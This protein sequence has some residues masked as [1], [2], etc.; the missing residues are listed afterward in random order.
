MRGR[1]H[2]GE[3]LVYETAAA[4]QGEDFARLMRLLGAI[5]TPA[6]VNETVDSTLMVLADAMGAGL[7]CVASVVGDRLVPTAAYGVTPDDPVFQSGWAL[8]GPGRDALDRGT[9]VARAQ[10][11]PMDRP[12]HLRRA[13]AA[14]GAWVPLTAGAD[15]A[16]ELL[17]LLRLDGH[18]F[19]PAELQVLA[20][21]AYQMRSAVEALERVNA[22][23]R[24]AEAGPGL[25]RHV[26]LPSLWDEAVVLLR[27][28]TGTDSAF[29]VTL[30]NDIF[31]LATYTGTDESIPRRWPRTTRTMPNWDVLSTGRAYVGPREVI[32][33]R[34]DET[35]TSPTVLC[36]PVMQEGNVVALLG[37]TGHRS[38]SFGKTGVDIATVLANYLSAAV[39]KAHLY[40]S[41]MQR[42]RELRRR[43]SSDPLTGLAN[44][45]QL[46][47][48]IAAALPT[49]GDSAVGLLFCDIDKFK[50]VNDR[51]GHEFGDELLQQV[52]LR[53]RTAIRPGDV[54]ARFGGDEFVVI[55]NDVRDLA[56]VTAASRV[57]HGCLGAPFAIR[58]EQFQVSASIGAV[59]G[60]S[61]TTASVLL[62]SADAAMYE[63]KAKGC[64]RTEVFD[65]DASH[66]SMDRL[67]LRAELAFALDRGELAIVYQ[68]ICEL[69]SRK[70][71]AFEALLRWTHPERGVVVPDLFIPLAEETGSIVPIGAWVLRESCRRLSEWQ[72]LV[73]DANLTMGVNITAVQL[74]NS[75]QDLLDV[76]L[77]TGVDPDHVW[78]EVTERM[79]TSGDIADQ[80]ARLRSAGVHFALDDFGMSYSSLMY[81]KRF[82]V[83]GIKIDRTFV[84]PMT[85]DETE[86]AIVQAILAL[87]A[88][89]SVNVIAEGIETDE[90]ADALLDLGCVY[91]QGYLLG[92]PM[93]AAESV[94]ALQAQQSD[95]AGTRP[96]EAR[97]TL[98]E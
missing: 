80:V 14:S 49:A 78:L 65:D 44:R 41:L 57:I 2:H 56:D 74:E 48:Q 17:V 79:D 10:V 19:Q 28:L 11:A 89:L 77:R 86:L 18:E 20:T 4:A 71:L 9:P 6:P 92:R 43:A 21:A 1:G 90:Q 66:R 24:L 31:T 27:D 36:V 84:A 16:D 87:G 96:A 33:E 40:R 46:S 59:L 23:E 81:L 55:V 3:E 73:P 76:I 91:G 37:A 42:E 22:I 53:M 75:S 26:D 7:V 88:S 72:R 63:A 32:A 50:A 93:T 62:R 54:L 47:Q 39:T 95:P 29:I 67:D 61:G 13:P 82:P 60:R 83:E 51:L 34:P 25:A 58:G 98:S 30:A 70:I 5:G 15:P 97:Y 8:G 64:G 94:R 69:N 12:G 45:T 85:D 68:P 38:R 52:A 35:D